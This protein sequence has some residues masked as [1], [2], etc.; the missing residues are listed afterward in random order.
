MRATNRKQKEEDGM[1]ELE[2]GH[3]ARPRL[4]SKSPWN[5]KN[6]DGGGA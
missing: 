3:A 4:V 5:R 1:K 2:Q 6:Q